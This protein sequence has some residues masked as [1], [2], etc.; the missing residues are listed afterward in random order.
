MLVTIL[1]DTSILESFP[2]LT[3]DTVVVAKIYDP[4][5]YTVRGDE[6][7]GPSSTYMKYLY[8]NEVTAYRQL[9]ILQGNTIPRFLGEFTYHP[10]AGEVV[11]LILLEYLRAP[12]FQS[13]DCLG[14]DEKILLKEESDR[15][16]DVL[17]SCGVSHN[18]LR[19]ENLLWDSQTGFWAL[20][21][22]DATFNDE[23][24]FLRDKA[25]IESLVTPLE[26]RKATA[27]KVFSATCQSVG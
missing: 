8:N 13:V 15:F 4:R 27:T 21:F 22:E 25:Y 19:A 11:D 20:D 26:E 1:D 9:N 16:L 10:T 14:R 18:D 6:W 12:P 7:I 3:S 5:Q 17:R 23:Q 2:G 24:G